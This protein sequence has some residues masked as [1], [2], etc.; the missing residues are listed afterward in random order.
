MAKDGQ[1]ERSAAHARR[2]GH[3]LCA[4]N[5]VCGTL[6]MRHASFPALKGLLLSLGVLQIPIY[7]YIC[8]Y[9]LYIY[10]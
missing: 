9:I 8:I 3:D 10:I 7:V 4:I 2:A 5:G 1:P 6:C